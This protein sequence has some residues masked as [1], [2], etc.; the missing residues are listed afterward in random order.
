ME[1][2]VHIS[3]TAQLDIDELYNHIANALNAPLTAVRYTKGITDT[4]NKLSFLGDAFS[5][6]QSKFL[7]RHYGYDIRT[8]YYK[9]MTIVYKIVANVVIIIRVMPGALIQ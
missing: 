8:M 6:S 3:D 2:I 5:I 7:Q 1:Y 9:K 4:I